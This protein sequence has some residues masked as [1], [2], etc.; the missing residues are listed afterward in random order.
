MPQATKAHTSRRTFLRG[1]A[2]AAVA[3]PIMALPAVAASSA[4]AELFAL[5]PKIAE[6]ANRSAK[7]GKAADLALNAVYEWLKR[8]PEPEYRGLI[9]TTSSRR[10]CATTEGDHDFATFFGNTVI[11]VRRRKDFKGDDL[12]ARKRL[13]SR[14][15]LDAVR[16]A[17][18]AEADEAFGEIDSEL[19]DA[20]QPFFEI[21]ATTLDGLRLK[22]RMAQHDETL[23]DIIVKDL[24]ALG[25]V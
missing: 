18:L 3:A 9:C 23:P 12:A 11:E 17:G 13:W 22:A 16:N 15:K 7:A 25:R 20:L 6:M 8:N 5:E 24:L 21:P 19:V 2:A 10:L 4:E 14:R 1:T